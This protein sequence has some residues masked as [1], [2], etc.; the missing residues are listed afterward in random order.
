MLKRISDILLTVFAVGVTVALFAGA[1]ALLAFIVA[2]ILGGK[3]GT[4]IS[5]FVHGKYFPWVIRL[6]TVSAFSGL[7]G[8][9]IGKMS[10]L[11]V[12]QTNKDEADRA[13]TEK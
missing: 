3:A 1:L 6:A 5:L 4:E 9:Y 2:L 12:R 7:F 11:S 10:A 8:M 13:K